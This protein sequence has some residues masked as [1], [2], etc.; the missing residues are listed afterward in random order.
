M[1]NEIVLKDVPSTRYQG[2][3]RAILPWIFSNL[4]KL[5]FETVLDG[6]GGTGSVSYL[7]KLM[8][9]KVT[10]ND[11]LVSN[12]LTAVALIENDTVILTE[13]DVNFIIHR[14]GFPYPSFIRD[15]FRNIYYLDK[16]NRWLDTAVYNIKMLSEKYKGN[17]LRKKQAVAYHVLFQSCLSKRPFNLFHRKNL[18]IRTSSVKRTFGNK[19]TW[20]KTFDDLFV[21]VNKEISR[22]IFVSHQE[23]RAMRGDVLKV[24][25]SGY[26]LVYFDP[27]Y[28]RLNEKRPKDYCSMYHF[29]EG[30]VD[31]ENWGTYIDWETSNRRLKNEENKWH[32]KCL[33]D[34]FDSLFERFRDSIIVVSYGQPGFPSIGAIKKVLKTYKK[35][36]QVVRKEYHY[37]LNENRKNGRKMYEVLLIGR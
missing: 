17:I 9:K 15:T 3:K 25:N 19:T 29:L 8:G 31:Y 28:A 21:T 30:L 33:I 18:Y 16:E 4:K 7:F 20:E 2:S 24:K 23:N 6:F 37:R 13:E 35:N 5:K 26:D 32:E 11:I 12:Y 10:F 36:V 22:K 14:N 1:I 34:N 27:P